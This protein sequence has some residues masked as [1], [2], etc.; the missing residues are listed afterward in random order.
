MG[1]LRYEVP[2]DNDETGCDFLVD[3]LSVCR[4]HTRDAF[5]IK[6]NLWLLV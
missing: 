2:T 6:A 3:G 4:F 1:L 5:I